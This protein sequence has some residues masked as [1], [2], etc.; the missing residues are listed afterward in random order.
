MALVHG[1]GMGMI[2]RTRCREGGSTVSRLTSQRC[3]CMGLFERSITAIN[4]ISTA[5]QTDG[6][7]IIIYCKD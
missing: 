1:C 4:L 7:E 2:L 3:T 5:F 6:E